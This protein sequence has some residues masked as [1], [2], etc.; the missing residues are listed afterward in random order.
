MASQ[1]GTRQLTQ[2]RKLRLD[3]IGYWSEIKLDIIR[4]YAKAYSIILAAQ[5]RPPLY[6]V[7]IDAFAGAGVHV[8]K[9]TGAEVEGSPMI[10]VNTQPP[11]KEY[12]F[13]DLDGLK[14]ENLRGIFGARPDVR[15]RMTGKGWP[16]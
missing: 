5:N 12:H 9:T 1:E 10:A 13:I 3:E 2:R 11:F 16:Y 14:V 7:Y 15:Q 4:D 6:H 8:S